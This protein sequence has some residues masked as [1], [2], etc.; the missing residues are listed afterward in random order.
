MNVNDNNNDRIERRKSKFL[1]LLTAPRT[2]SNTYAQVIRRNR[3]QITW[4][5]SGVYHVQH[6]VWHVVRRGSSAIKSDRVE[7][8]FILD[9][10]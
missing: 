2:V 7:I 1:L 8:A 3:V 5:T 6:A 10:F 9:L 4:N